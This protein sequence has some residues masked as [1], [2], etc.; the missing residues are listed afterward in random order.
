LYLRLSFLFD[1]I[2]TLFISI[3]LFI[4]AIIMVY[5]YSYIIPY[6]KSPY[7]LWL[8][9]LFVLAMLF[10]ISISNLFFIILGWDGLGLIS[11]FLIIFYQNQQSIVSGIFTVLINRLGD[12]FYLI[13]LILMFYNYSD[14]SVFSSNLSRNRTIFFLILTF[15]TKSAIYPFSP[16]LPA[17][18]AAPTPI[19]ALVH[20]STLVTAGLYLII[21]FSY[22][23][24]SSPIAIQV[25]SAVCIFTSFYA[26]LNTVFECDL[27][28]II[29][30][31]TLSHLGFIGI[32]F[33]LGIL[34]LRFFHLLVHALFKSLLFISIGDI[35]VNM[36]HSQDIRYLSKGFIYT[37]FSSFTLIIS[38]LNLLGL[39]NIS[40]YFSK[41]LIL[42]RI[43][44]CNSSF[45]FVSMVYVNVLSTYFYSYK[46]IFF[47]F[48][49][50]KLTPFKLFN[51][52][53][54]LHYILLL[55][56]C[57]FTLFFSLIFLTYFYS[58]IVFYFLSPSLKF[59]PLF[60]NLVRCLSL[61]LFLTL[62]SSSVSSYSIFS[63]ILFL[64][65]VCK[66]YSSILYLNF[67]FNSVK[68]LE[69]GLANYS[70][71]KLTLSYFCR[72]SRFIHSSLI[73]I[74]LTSLF[75]FLS[76]VFLSLVSLS[77]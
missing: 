5:C 57:S 40:G 17:A 22:L 69:I 27:K 11:F 59:L 10:V 1:W 55:T 16:W 30:L 73:R 34:H 77:L 49:S 32:S 65:N 76:L 15:I 52:V 33:S 12:G 75:F 46:L 25:L 2:S 7:F 53:Y 6:N 45:I 39:P 29:A 4:S 68:R 67:L 58:Y 63:S 51:S 23:L 47:R 42:E 64:N 35:I 18:I 41:D 9:S 74:H 48:H 43:N 3:V 13:S 31:S 14:F 28:K 44:Y 21:R 71:N 56:L 61:F 70:F 37:P 24:Y 8:T 38:V 36:D 62:P 54:T 66:S 20:S 26:G 60:L 19:S 50:P 72:I